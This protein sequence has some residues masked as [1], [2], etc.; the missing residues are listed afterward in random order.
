MSALLRLPLPPF[1]YRCLP[2]A[3]SSILSLASFRCVCQV[4]QAE[5]FGKV[6]L[7]E[8]LDTLESGTRPL[9]LAARKRLGEEKGAAAL[10]PWNTGFAMAG[11]VTKRLDPY[12]P[13]EKSVEQWGRSFAA[14]GISYEGASMNLDLLDRKGKYS[15]GFCHWPQ[16][17]WV[18]PDG[19]WQP[20]VTHFTSL[21]DVCPP[22]T[23]PSVRT[24]HCVCQTASALCCRR[25]LLM[26]RRVGSHG[27]GGC[28]ACCRRAAAA[29]NSRA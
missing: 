29:A 19:S 3:S 12:F 25:S 2:L 18:K 10:E 15:N 21:A 22:G 23:K 20:T 13:F 4:T 8:I 27:W 6:A 26:P 17:A 9:M 16:P 1:V 14:M 11:D 24:R 5:G 28:P 7:F